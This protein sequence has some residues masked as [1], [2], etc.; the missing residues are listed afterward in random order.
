MLPACAGTTQ[1]H[2]ARTGLITNADFKRFMGS[3]GYARQE[4]W[5]KPG[6]MWKSNADVSR[7]LGW[8]KGEVKDDSGPVTGVSWYE[9]QAF[10]RFAQ[11]SLPALKSSDLATLGGD[12]GQTRESESTVSGPV[13][14]LEESG[15]A[16]IE[17]IREAIR[18]RWTYPCVSDPLSRRCD[19]KPTFLVILFGVL[20][21]GDIAYVEPVSPSGYTVMDEAAAGAIKSAA[22]FPPVPESLR[23]RGIPIMA[24][25]T[26]VV[27]D[28]HGK[29]PSPVWEWVGRGLESGVERRFRARPERMH[30]VQEMSNAQ[31]RL[32]PAWVRT[33]LVTFRCNTDAP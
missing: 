26:Y 25:F 18:N 27:A 12:P 28:S 2:G 31:F 7:P 20:K 11:S 32:V 22:P 21:T 5:T 3:G 13:T 9:A 33:P 10:C 23:K 8:E 6:W 29:P 30:V 14:W 24:T 17:G 16:Y 15:H 19:Y 4:L 1:R